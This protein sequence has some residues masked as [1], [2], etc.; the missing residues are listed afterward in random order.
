MQ[1]WVDRALR[2]L[3]DKHLISGN[4]RI[5]FSLTHM[6]EKVATNLENKIKYSPLSKKREVYNVRKEERVLEAIRTSDAYKKYLL[7]ERLVGLNENEL[8]RLFFGT[9]ET[10]LH[11]IHK[12]IEFLINYARDTGDTKLIEF[13]KLCR[14][15]TY[16]RQ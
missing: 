7:D 5:G 8:K 12:N 11:S 4:H 15:S 9:L 13:L 1:K 3:R 2:G 16:D 6:G 10:P 14:N